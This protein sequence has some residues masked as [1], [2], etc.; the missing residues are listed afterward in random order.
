M[1]NVVGLYAGHTLATGADGA[2][3]EASS[4]KGGKSTA[5]SRS[6][7]EE[8]DHLTLLSSTDCDWMRGFFAVAALGSWARALRMAAAFTAVELLS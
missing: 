1:P 8:L 3:A 7:F 6:V 4:D 2:A 5:K